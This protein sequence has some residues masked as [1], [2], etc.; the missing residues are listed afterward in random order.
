MKGIVEKRVKCILGVD[1]FGIK[2]TLYLRSFY[3]LTISLMNPE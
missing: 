3:I 1:K 2:Y